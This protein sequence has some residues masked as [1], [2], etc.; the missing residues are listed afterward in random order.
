MT[1]PHPFQANAVST[2]G[3]A[4]QAP[5]GPRPRRGVSQERAPSAPRARPEHAPSTPRVRPECWM[6]FRR[7]EKGFRKGKTFSNLRKAIQHSGRARGVLGACS[8]RARGVLWARSGRAPG[9]RSGPGQRLHPAFLYTKIQYFCIGNDR[10]RGPV[11]PVPGAFVKISAFLASPGK[12]EMYYISKR[13]TSIH[14][15]H[16]KITQKRK[17]IFFPFGHSQ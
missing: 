3:N 13:F 16:P 5:T 1:S 2:E 4:D 9:D 8:G 15:C 14:F 10:G 12:H 17:F 7:L 11:F 6:A